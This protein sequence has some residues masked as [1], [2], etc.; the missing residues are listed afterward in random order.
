MKNTSFLSIVLQ[1]ILICNILYGGYK[2]R[3]VYQEEAT[4]TQGSSKDNRIDQLQQS[5]DDLLHTRLP[6]WEAQ[7]GELIQ[8]MSIIDY[9]IQP[10]TIGRISQDCLVQIN[11]TYRDLY[12]V[13]TLPMMDICWLIKRR[14]I[15]S[16]K[17]WIERYFTRQGGLKPTAES[18]DLEH[19]KLQ[20]ALLADK[21]QFESPDHA[22]FKQK[23]STPTIAVAI[24]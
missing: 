8:E 15:P 22:E 21:Q 23:V 16:D 6:D 2:V 18:G 20:Q 4:A 10:D 17:E 5:L 11:K 7:R 19:A 1:A 13:L 12:G 14:M 9:P 24:Y 3:Q